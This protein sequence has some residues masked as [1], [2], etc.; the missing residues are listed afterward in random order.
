MPLFG[1][2]NRWGGGKHSGWGW[3]L[4]DEPKKSG[5]GYSTIPIVILAGTALAIIAKVAS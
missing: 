3:Y 1:A 2:P 4:D 5:S